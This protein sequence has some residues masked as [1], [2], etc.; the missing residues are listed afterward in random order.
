MS[1]QMAPQRTFSKIARIAA[2][3]GAL[4]IAWH[5]LFAAPTSGLRLPVHSLSG[6][7]GGP[8]RIQDGGKEYIEFDPFELPRLLSHADGPPPGNLRIAVLEHALFHD[9]E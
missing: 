9:G 8:V 1:T 2:A 7:T 5:Y 3:L 4:I 6:V